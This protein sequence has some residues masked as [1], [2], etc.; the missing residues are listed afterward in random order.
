MPCD[1][2]PD[3]L[4]VGGGVAG[5]TA[6]L[7]LAEAG[8]SPLVL[9]ANPERCGGRLASAPPVTL[10]AS[11]DRTGD[12][13]TS[14][15]IF[16]AEHGI[17]G[18]WAQYRNL[19]AL[20]DRLGLT[21]ELVP[22]HGQEWLLGR[23]GRI[24]RME[25]GRLV[26]WSPL[27]A[28]FHHA[29]LLFNPRFLAT[30]SPTD[31]LRLPVALGSLLVA[32]GIDP[33]AEGATLEG[34]TLADF[35]RGWPDSLSAFAIAL[36]RSGL[37]ADLED[38]PLAGWLAFLRFY[39]LLRRD[40][41]AFHYLGR[42]GGTVIV[43]PLVA[44][45]RAAGGAIALGRRAT[46]LERVND[47]GWHLV[48]ESQASAEPRDRDLG[49]YGPP[50]GEVVAAHVVIALDAP[51]AEQ[52]VRSSPDLVG[53]ADL[54][55]PR[56]QPTVVVRLWTSTTPHLSAEAG[57]LG[58]DFAADNFFWLH[59]FQEPFIAWHRATG[60]GAVELHVYAPLEL[61]ESEDAVILA[62][63]TGD[64][65]RAWPVTRGHVLHRTL[66]RNPPTH[67]LF[68]VGTSERHL[69]VTAPWPGIFCA[70]DWI[71]HLSPAFF[72]ERACVTGLEAANR[73]LVA[74][75]RSPVPVLPPASPEPLAAL[76]AR[77]LGALRRTV[78]S[79]RRSS[80]RDEPP[81]PR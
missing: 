49:Q 34:R 28:P 27:P 39:A 75:G 67:T 56:G 46:R 26:R 50:S 59:T 37:S 61:I 30:L 70:G 48:W 10:P 19:R 55:W 32:V 60:G 77:G 29:A 35:C 23:Q 31:Y 7:T 5:L 14:T 4:V 22:A 47:D 11:A 3:V 62:R 13:A 43:D 8:L 18:I 41:Q 68:D 74:R 63:V 6:A 2:L 79:R 44:A 15:W 69:G 53:G 81:A 52:L 57:V 58:G 42:D 78:R 33:L 40:A 9:E 51:G 64:V 71:R 72:L 73:V 54:R 24:Q 17:H 66:R 38:V 45:V 65:A 12:Q 25:M 36:A 76:L 21:E 20:L 1:L 80:D 16:P